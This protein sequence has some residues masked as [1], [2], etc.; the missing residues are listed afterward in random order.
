[1]STVRITNTCT[2]QTYKTSAVVFCL[3]S[4]PGAQSVTLQ[5]SKKVHMDSLT[6]IILQYND[7]FGIS[8]IRNALD[9]CDRV[10][11][12]RTASQSPFEMPDDLDTQCNQCLLHSTSRLFHPKWPSLHLKPGRGSGEFRSGGRL[13]HAYLIQ[14]LTRSL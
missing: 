10:G 14:D 3:D 9:H 2:L 8:A 5:P 4:P 1:M 11:T 7:A 13:R 12:T 6:I